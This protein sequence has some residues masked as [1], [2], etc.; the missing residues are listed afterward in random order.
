MKE[1]SSSFFFWLCSKA[2]GDAC[3]LGSVLCFFAARLHGGGAGCM[4]V[5][6][7]LKFLSLCSRVGAARLLGLFAANYSL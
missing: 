6:L 5:L 1:R 7:L 4:E 3:F 2:V